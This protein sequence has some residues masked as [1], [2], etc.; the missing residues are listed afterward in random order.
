MIYVR[1]PIEFNKGNI[2]GAF[3][4]PL[5]DD[6]QRQKVGICYKEQGQQAAI[7][8][9]H[10]LVSGDIKDRTIAAWCDYFDNNKNTHIFCFRGGLRSKT[11]QQWIAQTGRDIP[12]IKGGYKAFRQYL[13]QAS[14]TLINKLPLHIIAGKTGSGKTELLDTLNNIVDLEGLA[15]HRGSAFGKQLSSQPTQ[16]NFEN[17]LAKRLLQLE[18]K[19]INNLIV[20]DES[21]TIGKCA[22]PQFLRQK[23]LCSPVYLLE[24][25][26]ESRAQRILNDYVISMTQ[27]YQAQYGIE[28][29]FEHFGEYLKAAFD[30]IRK[31]LGSQRHAELLT[32]LNQALAHQ[33]SQNNVNG[34]LCWIEV[35]LKEYYD[36]IYQY[37]LTKKQ[38]RIIYRGNKEQLLELIQDKVQSKQG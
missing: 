31:R 35:L 7:K 3:S 19:Q 22:L 36:P 34:H 8:L 28:Q 33:R 24:D 4:L 32:M 13:M 29:G 5:M 38:Q 25:E 11:S 12:L 27:Q 37:Q 30:G 23:M 14:E 18:H 10:E 6:E 1:S 17:K 15:N 26:F 20:E 16:I 21:R 2:L 9:G